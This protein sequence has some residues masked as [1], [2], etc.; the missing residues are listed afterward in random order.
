MKN[1]EPSFQFFIVVFSTFF[2]A[3]AVVVAFFPET[4]YETV[5]MSLYY[6]IMGAFAFAIYAML[7]WGKS[8]S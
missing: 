5:P 7:K 1:L 3:M 4:I 2:T 6:S 8:T